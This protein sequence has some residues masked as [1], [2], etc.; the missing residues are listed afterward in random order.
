MVNVIKHTQTIFELR[1]SEDGRFNSTN[2]TMIIVA[3]NMKAA[4][5]IAIAVKPAMET[6]PNFY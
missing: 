5:D 3:N 6:F 1:E 4:R 2:P